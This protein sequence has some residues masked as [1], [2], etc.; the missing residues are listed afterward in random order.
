MKKL[1]IAILA[2]FFDEEVDSDHY[3]SVLSSRLRVDG[4]QPRDW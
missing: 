2:V 4:F 1:W 3:S